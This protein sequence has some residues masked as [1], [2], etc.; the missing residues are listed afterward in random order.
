VLNSKGFK[1]SRNTILDIFISLFYNFF[2]STN[3]RSYTSGLPVVF[4]VASGVFFSWLSQ[5]KRSTL[6]GLHS[7]VVG[8]RLFSLPAAAGLGL[9]S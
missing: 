4:R 2:S 1:G 5:P 9:F 3:F 8:S 6:F 7:F